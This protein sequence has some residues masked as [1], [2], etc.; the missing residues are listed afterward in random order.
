MARIDNFGDA[1]YLSYESDNVCKWQPKCNRLIDL[2]GELDEP[3]PE[4]LNPMS[5]IY[6]LAHYDKMLFNLSVD[7]INEMCKIVKKPSWFK[8]LTYWYLAACLDEI[9]PITGF[10]HEN[11]LLCWNAAKKN[12]DFSIELSSNVFTLMIIVEINHLIK[13]QVRINKYHTFERDALKFRE[14]TD[15]IFAICE[16]IKRIHGGKKIIHTSK[17]ARK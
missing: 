11:T 12:D 5:N 4:I 14:Y 10:N 9:E 7:M 6:D 8:Y 2:P 17:S 13:F 16:A 3:L 1:L 15:S